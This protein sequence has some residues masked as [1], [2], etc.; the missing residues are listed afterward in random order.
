MNNDSV[1]A[2]WVEAGTLDFCSKSMGS[3]DLQ[4]GTYESEVMHRYAR[5]PLNSEIIVVPFNELGSEWAKS[6]I[7][8]LRNRQEALRESV[9][10]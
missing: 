7:Q 6:E 10:R 2:Y 4:G 5:D 1:M 9:N 8:R 3:A